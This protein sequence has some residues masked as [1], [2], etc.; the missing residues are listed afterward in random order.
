MKFSVALPALL[1]A[2]STCAFSVQGP[3]SSVAARSSQNR[4]RAFVPLKMSEVAEKK[5]EETFE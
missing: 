4:A 5:G 3:P 1:L 2:G